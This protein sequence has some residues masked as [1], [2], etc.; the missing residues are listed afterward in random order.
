MSFWIPTNI[1]VNLWIDLIIKINSEINEIIIN[2][3]YIYIWINH[4]CI[5]NP[6]NGTSLTG[7]LHLAA[8]SISLLTFNNDQQEE[9]TD[10]TGIFIPTLIFQ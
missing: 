9:P 5:I 6:H 1:V 8:H 10:I 3:I 4:E 7:I 2:I